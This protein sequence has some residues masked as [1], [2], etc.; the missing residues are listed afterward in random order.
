V[1]VGWFSAL[2]TEEKESVTVDAQ[3]RWHR[4]PP[5]ALLPIPIPT[6]RKF[7]AKARNLV[8]S[9]FASVISL[10]RGEQQTTVRRL[11]P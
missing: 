10:L 11:R 2:I 7:P 3:N 9:T 8:L 4:K 6:P 5:L 1:N